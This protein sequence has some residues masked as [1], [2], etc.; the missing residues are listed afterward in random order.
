MSAQ[1]V[2]TELGPPSGSYY[3]AEDHMQIHADDADRSSLAD[4]FLNYAEQGVDFLFDAQTHRIKKMVLHTN[5]LGHFDFNSYAKCNFELVL[6]LHN[7]SCLGAQPAATPASPLDPVC[8]PVV[9]DDMG[10][11]STAPLNEEQPAAVTV[12]ADP[13]A[14]V[15]KNKR[16]SGT[17]ATIL[18]DCVC[19]KFSFD[20][21]VLGVNCRR[22]R[23]AASQ[24]IERRL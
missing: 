17:T 16:K 19:A 3:K 9:L 23:R 24:I 6:P 18:R 12:H 15:K 4:Y 13:P 1:T 20:F 10:D 21:V 5:L 22:Q 7:R 14:A 8:L 11:P 2:L